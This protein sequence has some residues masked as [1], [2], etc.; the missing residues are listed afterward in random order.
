MRLTAAV[1]EWL[2]TRLDSTPKRVYVRC[3]GGAEVVIGANAEHA[4]HGTAHASTEREHF[5]KC[6]PNVLSRSLPALPPPLRNELAAAGVLGGVAVGAGGSPDTGSARSGSRCA[7]RSLLR[8]SVTGH[9]TR[10]GPYCTISFI[11]R[12]VVRSRSLERPPGPG[13]ES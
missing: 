12:E 4:T 13:G 1:N 3:V 2:R 6:P 7:I 5:V 9:G 8:S 10:R 11:A